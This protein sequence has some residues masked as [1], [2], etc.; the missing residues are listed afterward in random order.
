M[1]TSDIDQVCD[2]IA[3]TLGAA[4]GIAAVDSYGELQEGV[5]DVPYM[6]VYPEEGST[7]ATGDGDRST[8]RGGVRVTET[9]FNVDVYCRQRS[10]LDQDMKA[11]VDAQRAVQAKLEEQR[12]KPYFGNSSIKGFSWTWR[13][14]AF[15]PEGSDRVYA[16]LR[17][18]VR[19]R[20][21]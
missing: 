17:F 6:Q 12:T 9:A 4:T 19:V 20:Q 15:Q 11:V 16:G 1:A 10:N 13:R 3:T 8:F 18:V 5:P 7:D 21:F 2:D 14:A